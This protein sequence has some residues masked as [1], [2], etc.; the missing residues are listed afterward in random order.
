[1]EPDVAH[2][3][4][5]K[6][7]TSISRQSYIDIIRNLRHFTASVFFLQMLAKL[8]RHLLFRLSIIQH[9]RHCNLSWYRKSQYIV[10]NGSPQ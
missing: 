4:I 7:Y 6:Q 3:P 8:S 5:Y 10:S 9:P 2:H 1:M